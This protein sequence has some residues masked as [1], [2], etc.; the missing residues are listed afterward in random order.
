MPQIAQM[1]NDRVSIRISSEDKQILM[2]AVA[3][4]HTNITEFVL[5]QILPQAKKIVKAH[6]KQQFSQRDLAMIFELM[7]NPPKPNN[8]L[9]NAVQLAEKLYE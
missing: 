5:Q 9:Q 3:L 2:Q 7:D 8:R 4:S 6:Q 1:A